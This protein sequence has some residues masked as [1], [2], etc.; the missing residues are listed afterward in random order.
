MVRD[1]RT[2]SQNIFMVSAQAVG[3]EILLEL[4]PVNSS[5]NKELKVAAKRLTE[6][7]LIDV[8][9][10]EGWPL[11]MLGYENRKDL[12]YAVLDKLK[13]VVEN[14][15]AH[16]ELSSYVETKMITI[17]RVAT[18]EDFE[19]ELGCIEI[20][21]QQT[22]SDLRILIKHELDP[23]ELPNQFR[24]L[25]KGVMCSI[26]QEVFRRAWECLPTCFITPKT[27]ESQEMGT[28]TDDIA[29]KRLL[30]K[31][32]PKKEVDN[33]A[34][35]MVKGQRRVPGKYNPIPLPTL[36]VVHE[37][38]PEIYLLH[39]GKDLLVPGDIIR[40]GN[41]LGR[42]YLVS[43]VGSKV[44]Q[45]TIDSKVIFIDPE[46]DLANEPDFN[47]PIQNN[48]PW[49][50]KSNGI[51]MQDFVR[52]VQ[53]LKSSRE[54]GYSYALPEEFAG[55][56]EA[57]A[58]WLDKVTAL[59]PTAAVPAGGDDDA[60]SHGHSATAPP[61]KPSKKL[62]I[63]RAFTDCWIWKCIPAKDDNRPKWRQLYDDG[64]VHYTYEMRGS[65]EFVTYY[66]VPAHFSYLEVLCTDSRVPSLSHHH[67]RVNEMRNIPLE[68]Y[69]R[70][71][72]DKLTEWTPVYRKGID[73]SK[74]IKLIRDVNAFPDLKRPAR[75][76][77]LD[78]IFQKLVK[79]DFGIV[80]KYISFP[81]FC[82]L[83]KETALI[84]F[85]A[86]RKKGNDDDAS[87]VGSLGGAGTKKKGKDDDES[88]MMTDDLS[89]IGDEPT[90]SPLK[91][92]IS[93]MG[94]TL[95]KKPSQQSLSRAPSS[96]TLARK[97]SVLTKK[98]S[99]TLKN[100][101]EEETPSID[102]EH[103][104]WAYQKFVL[105]F[106]MMFPNWYDA[107]WK[108][109]KMAAMRK[110]AIPYCAATRIAA[111]LRGF[112]AKSR[113]HRFLKHH[114]KL[115]ANIRRKLSAQKTETLKGLLYEDW[116]FRRRFY[117]TTRINA[118]IRR[119]LKRCWYLHVLE[120]I[121]RQ[122]II[123]L[124]ARRQRLKKIRLAEKKTV[125]YSEAVR[126]N[127]VMVFITLTRKD[128]RNYT[129]DYGINIEVYAPVSQTTFRFTLEDTELRSY[130]AIELQLDVVTVGQIMDIRNLKRLMSSRLIVHKGANKSSAP[131]VILS[132][133][134]LG[135]RGEKALTRA[136]R[137]NGHLFIC[138]IF[139]TVDDI[140][141]QC[142]HQISCKIF[143]CKMTMKEM[144]GWIKEEFLIECKDEAARFADPPLLHPKNKRNFHAWVLD[145]LV[146]DTR[147]GMFR[148][149]FA[150]HLLKSKKGEMILRIQ[151][152]WRRA[153]VRPTIIR[154]LDAVMI[155]IYATPG[156]TESAYYLNRLTGASSWE[157]PKLL[158]HYDL[159]TVP[160]SRWVDIWYY[161]QQG[162]P[163][164]HYVN[165]YTGKYTNLVPEKAARTIQALARNH[166]LK[167][168]SMPLK[169]FVKAGQLFK[170]AERKY[171]ERS[172]GGAL[173]LSA[174]VNFALMKHVITL[175]E[176]EAKELYR[177][178]VEL[179]EAN[180]LVTRAYAFFLLGTCPAPLA[181]N[182]ERALV[183]LRDAD[184]KDPEM[185][186][187]GGA[188]YI[189][190]FACL[191]KPFDVRTLLN[192]ALVQ[193]Y[194]Y[195]DTKSY[196][197]EKLLR[198]A[199]AL[200]PFDERVMEIWKLLRD[201][202]PERQLLYSS[203]M[204]R[205]TT[206]LDPKLEK[207]KM[208]HGRDVIENR[209][210][211][212]WCYVEKDTFNVSKKFAGI[213]RPYWYNPATGEEMDVNP[214]FN[215]EWE[216]RKARSILQESTGT[217]GLQAYYDPLTADYFECFTLTNT[218]Q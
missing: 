101:I 117:F 98:G 209:L 7:E 116:W 65:D 74:F 133:H 143:T 135:Q 136:K 144:R 15:K 130:M 145:H 216:V 2:I 86:K 129:K 68:F 120:Q 13:V 199:L 163:H 48:C 29:Q 173:K 203:M 32:A 200:A 147:H 49:P 125:I 193:C 5:A 63:K 128:P 27:I 150:C 52:P 161:D 192:L 46:Y 160:T 10:T 30:T 188:Y 179:S 146:V 157:K 156:D 106:I 23:D 170:T 84:R 113:L 66:R 107:A 166:L 187:F 99:S 21:N 103:I 141:V 97:G 92:G 6:A 18:A 12:V 22:L 185:G 54:L 155:K 16:L 172:G 190:Q 72:F 3:G 24:F 127:G 118:W 164:M 60:Q 31:A 105:D 184:R 1:V 51:Y 8:V 112:V 25:Y 149:L 111:S 102:P 40:I 214:D 122:Q 58:K 64:L 114:I 175:E 87:S 88:S 178:A 95:S 91:R 194:L 90:A 168:I 35:K 115:Q 171:G 176:D 45:F 56:L 177:Q 75:V 78:M 217:F 94:S 197:A 80:Q 151:S 82:Q 34:F 180:P 137:I 77:Q 139:E 126:V 205:T 47:L 131:L 148:V 183:L 153:L 186:S 85:P 4:K 100:I 26:R 154:M 59:D 83:L 96:S 158:A 206:V 198:R 108:E 81:G 9:Q 189:F 39:D 71:A 181:L 191:R 207:R 62:F 208:V 140:A 152:V 19:A 195:S 53:L 196:V 121:K 70:T 50:A 134:A 174:V 110:E 79:S 109:A 17:S 142:Y 20:N 162:T 159:P 69:L 215:H 93:R 132:K 36:C 28:E 57:T 73:R 42:D 14:D 33:N 138:K 37:G 43:A 201:R 55:Q 76:A 44:D 119:F 124:K 67:Q 165:P 61:K 182:R 202:F 210:W 123:V 38:K 169:H 41:V 167:T 89:S 204:R 218:Y 11:K 213:K 212:G 211:A 104:Q